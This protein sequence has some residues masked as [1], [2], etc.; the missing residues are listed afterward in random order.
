MSVLS[1]EVS[2]RVAEIMFNNPPVNALSEQMLNDYLAY[3]ERAAADD[4]VRAVIVGSRVPGRFC[5]GLNLAAIHAEG[6]TKVRS[7]LDRLYIK[8]TDVQF[9]MGKPTIA[10]IG[11]TARGGGMTLAI[12]CDMIVASCSATF[13][14]PEI[15]AGVLPSIHFTHLPRV[16][17]RHRAFELL[18]SGRAFDAHEA[19]DMGLICKLADDGKEMDVARALA[20]VICEKSPEVVRF[21][22][23]AFMQANDNGYRQ[24]VSAAADSF[25]SIASS[26]SAREGIAAFVEKRKPIW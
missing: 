10:A 22:R 8:M 14:Y 23:A 7:L 12:S 3:L 5:A 21:G 16:I 15:D 9:A 17:G 1:Y 6:P 20:Q 13:G 24:A 18:F 25:C 4:D 2:N 19:M 11:G 26:R